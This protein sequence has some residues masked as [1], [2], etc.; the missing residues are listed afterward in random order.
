MRMDGPELLAFLFLQVP[1]DQKDLGH[2]QQG[3]DDALNDIGGHLPAR[4]GAVDIVLIGRAV[5]RGVEHVLGGLAHGLER[6]AAGGVGQDGV[7]AGGAQHDVRA[8][9]DGPVGPLNTN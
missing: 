9:P 2:N 4:D 8:A 1:A 3:H 7:I 6:G 5:H